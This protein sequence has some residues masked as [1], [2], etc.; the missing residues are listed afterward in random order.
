MRKKNDIN[1]DSLSLI[2]LINIYRCTCSYISQQCT[3]VLM[4]QYLFVYFS[5]ECLFLNIVG[6]ITHQGCA[7]KLSYCALLHYIFLQMICRFLDSASSCLKYWSSQG[8]AQKS[9]YQ[10]E[11]N[12][13]K[14]GHSRKLSKYEEFIMTLT[15]LRLAVFTT[16][17][18]QIHLGYFYCTCF[19]N[20]YNMGQFDVQRFW[21]STLSLVIKKFLPK[22]FKR[23]YTNNVCIFDC[24][25]LFVRKP[26][27]PGHEIAADR[28]F[29]I[30][31]LLLERPAKL[32]M[33]FFFFYKEM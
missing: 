20:F 8:S 21:P 3:S 12:K 29:L 14:I 32:G 23:S 13:K 22:S 27:S 7:N 28:R 24:T 4:Y 26:R 1:S 25:E 5:I 2:F 16:F 15:R 18:Q 30:C 10:L 17:F 6:P 9:N 31:N 11:K 19:P 33:P